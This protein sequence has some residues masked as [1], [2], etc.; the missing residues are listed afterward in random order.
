MSSES[1]TEICDFS[2]SFI[3]WGIDTLVNT[4][5]TVSHQPPHTLNKVRVPAECFAQARHRETGETLSVLLGA[6]CKT[7]RV[8]VD[9]DI[10]TDPNADFFPIGSEE[11]ILIIK[12]WDRCDKGIMRYP[13]SL[14]LQPERQIEKAADAY[15][16][17]KVEIEK[18]HGAVIVDIEHM[19]DI[20]ESDQPMVSRTSIAAQNYDLVLEYPVKTVNWSPREKY[21]QVDTGPV[22]LPDLTVTF[23]EV[24][25]SFQVA[26]V[27]HTKSDWA[28]FLVRDR[29]RLSEEIEVYHYSKSLRIDCQNSMIAVQPEK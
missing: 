26:Y 10:W 27:A 29:N 17:Y 2:R 8:G 12:K 11:E 18:C 7:E 19:I 23:S 28:E 3:R 25:A 21:Y 14:G 9:K 16:H 1:F 6:A 22:L 20:L 15:T 24:H 4:P 13:E 5:I